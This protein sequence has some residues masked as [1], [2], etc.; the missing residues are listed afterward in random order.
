MREC[1]VRVLT[2][3][4][5]HVFFKPFARQNIV[6]IGLV[7]RNPVAGRAPLTSYAGSFEKFGR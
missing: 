2:I 6:H 4:R 5:L 1:A 3:P 7:V